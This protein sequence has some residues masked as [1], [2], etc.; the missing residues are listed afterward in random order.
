MTLISVIVPAI[1]EAGNIELLIQRIKKTIKEITDHYEIIVVDG[2]S[3]DD[4]ITIAKKAGA[5]VISQKNVGFGGALRDGF[6]AAKGQYIITIDG[7][8]SHEPEIITA[9]WK[10]KESA[11]I[12]IGSRYAAGGSAEQS[13][14]RKL[15]SRSLN[16]FFSIFLSIPVKDTSSNFRMYKR[17]V[18]QE[19]EITCTKFDVLQEILV[20]SLSR[21]FTLKEVPMH[22]Q[23]RQYG[24]SKA[25]I[26]SFVKAYSKTFVKLWTIRNSIQSCDYD[27]RAYYSII[28][29]QRY[30]QR[31][32][33]KII[34]NFL[35]QN[36]AENKKILDIG[37][38]TSKII[39]NLP[40][41]VAIDIQFHK[42]RYIQK[43]NLYRIQAS[44]FFIPFQDG[45]FDI[46]IS[47]Q[48][49]EHVPY[50]KEMFEEFF[51]VIKPEGFLIIG[52]P[53]Y[54]TTIWNVIEYIYKLFPNTYGD[55]HITHYSL[56]QIQQIFKENNFDILK[57]KYVFGAEL[58]ALARKQPANKK[59][60]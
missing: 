52:T 11:D 8:L 22:Y 27:E 21:G 31:K 17:K 37:C 33:Y 23:P 6:A 43:S 15:L 58:I 18:L 16:T 36:G 30:W 39:Q 2:H 28:P 48:V 7:D 19:I 13:L 57:V 20:L 60:A 45:T 14:T 4:T 35:E 29:I 47:S 3:T 26:I 38:G 10:E 55:E 54:N 42:L 24:V 46:I 32:R 44:T 41:A 51:R 25:K 12:L 56:K 59:K 53:D 1:N 9:M 40:S 50:K 34:M 49:I 5:T